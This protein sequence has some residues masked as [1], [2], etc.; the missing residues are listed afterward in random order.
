MKARYIRV[1]TIQQNEGR[2]AIRQTKDEIL[3][4]DKI[5]GLVPFNKRPKAI[6][7]INSIELGVINELVVSSVDRLGRNNIDILNTL[8]YFKNKNINVIIEDY[9]LQSIVNGKHNPI[10][11]LIT[12]ILSSIAQM[13][14][15]NILERTKQGIEIAKKKGIYKGRVLGSV[16]S[17]NEFLSKYP[18]LLKTIKDNPKLSL[19]KLSKLCDVSP[20]TVKKVIDTLTINNN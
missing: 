13:E 16:E 18:K 20:N 15:E 1:S 2:Q 14:R 19:R 3:Y 8:E 17:E 11:N 6:E 7:L 9:G 12:S 4:L 10:F 5:N